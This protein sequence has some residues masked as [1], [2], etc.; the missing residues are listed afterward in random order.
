LL[1]AAV[2][3]VGLDVVSIVPFLRAVRARERP[4]MT[5]V[6]SLYRDSAAL[7]PMALFSL[8]LTFFDMPAV[9]ASV[10]LGL[11]VCAVLAHWLPRSM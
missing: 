9:Y 1:V 2:G 11:L 6:F 3:A 8:L 10:A 5:M 7:A 4:E